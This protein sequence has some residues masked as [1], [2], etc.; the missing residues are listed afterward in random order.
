[1]STPSMMPTQAAQRLAGVG[2]HILPRAGITAPPSVRGAPT[3]TST[4]TPEA[5]SRLLSDQEV[6]IA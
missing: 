5:A 4:W 1:M 2:R 3:S 6:Q